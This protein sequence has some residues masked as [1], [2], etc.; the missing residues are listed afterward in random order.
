MN[1]S[2]LRTW[3]VDANDGIVATAGV[4]E[5][6]AGAGANEHALLTAA[7]VASIA[8]ALS[9]GGAKWAEYAAEREAQLRIIAEETAQLSLEPERGIEELALNFERRGVSQAV[10]RQVAEELSV[11]D[12]LAAKLDAQ[13]NIREV[14]ARTA[15][16]VVASGA[17]LFFLLGAAVPLIITLLVPAP[18]EDAAILLAVTASLIITSVVS[19]RGGGTLF[20]QTLARTLTVGLG[21]LGISYLIGTLIFA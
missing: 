19:A 17:V 13:H 6:F 11:Q 4:L 9:L 12:A 20:W 3:T 18:L 16:L 5:G 15:P 7:I 14:I 8:G 10:A 21:T 1:R 2:N